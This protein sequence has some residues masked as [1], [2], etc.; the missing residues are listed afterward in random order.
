VLYKQNKN[1]IAKMW[2]QSQT[3]KNK[4][5]KIIHKVTPILTQDSL[6][7]KP[8]YE[9]AWQVI[10]VGGTQVSIDYRNVPDIMNKVFY[11]PIPYTFSIDLDISEDM[12]PYVNAKAIFNI[13]G[14]LPFS[15]IADNVGTFTYHYDEMELYSEGELIYKG[16]DHPVPGTATAH[17]LY[18]HPWDE[19]SYCKYPIFPYWST[20]P[21]VGWRLQT[22]E[23][24]DGF[25]SFAGMVSVH[26]RRPF[27]ST[28]PI[29]DLY[30]SGFTSAG[31]GGEVYRTGR[32]KS[33]LY[34]ESEEVTSASIVDSIWSN[35]YFVKTGDNR[36]RLIVEGQTICRFPLELSG[37]VWED[38]IPLWDVYYENVEPVSW[39]KTIDTSTNLPWYQ[40]K[41]MQAKV[42]LIVSLTAPNTFMES[43]KY[44]I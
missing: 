8:A 17:F 23:E 43:K 14:A 42:K 15:G 36:Y 39:T 3:I 19:N 37:D 44:A 11:T 9:T 24:K 40:T 16:Q 7:A 31:P 30:N 4:T 20:T 26:V 18:Y 2:E 41:L 27:D 22:Q 25:F 28:L 13:P 29:Y 32:Y 5:N 10:Q 38:W 35:Q 1:K 33:I 21:Y 12:L 6:I 34:T